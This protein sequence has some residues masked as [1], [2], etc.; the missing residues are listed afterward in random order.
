[1]FV[2]SDIVTTVTRQCFP[3]WRRRLI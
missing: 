2:T 3:L 1:M